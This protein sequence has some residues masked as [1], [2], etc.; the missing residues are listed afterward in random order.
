M[1]ET[2]YYFDVYVVDRCTHAEVCVGSLMSRAEAAR[3]KRLF[4]EYDCDAYI[5]KYFYK[6]G[7][8]FEV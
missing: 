5:V 2:C 3:C 6:H 8:R 4:E 7:K 1:S